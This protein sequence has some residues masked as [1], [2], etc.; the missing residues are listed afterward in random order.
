[1]EM[2]MDKKLKFSL[3]TSLF[4]FAFPRDKPLLTFL[5][6][7]LDIR[8]FFSRNRFSQNLDHSLYT[9]YRDI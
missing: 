6:L 8:N 4:S 2:F 5:C 3:P 1:M 7:G 9:M